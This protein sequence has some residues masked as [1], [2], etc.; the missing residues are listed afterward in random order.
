MVRCLGVI[1]ATL[2]VTACAWTPA[3]AHP[4]DG[5]FAVAR[6]LRPT[7]AAR[8]PDGTILVAGY[9]AGGSGS[10]RARE[11]VAIR[12]DG[13]REA[14]R[15]FRATGIE[16]AHDGSVLGIDDTAHVIRRWIRGATPTVVAGI[17]DGQEGFSG[18]GGPATEARLHLFDSSHGLQPLRAGG[19]RFTDTNN[20]RIREVDPAGTIRTVTCCLPQ[21]T[22][23]A[24]LPDG[25]S[26]ATNVFGTRLVLVGHDGRRSKLLG[27]LDHVVA[28][29]T[30]RSGAVVFHQQFYD[31]LT[32]LDPGGSRASPYL[33]NTPSRPFDFAARGFFWTGGLSSDGRGGLFA[34]DQG[35][36]VYVTTRRIAQ[37]LIALRD[38]RFGPRRLEAVVETTRPGTAVLEVLRRGRVVHRTSA[39]V[40]AGHN[41][42][43]SELRARS[44]WYRVRV[45]LGRSTDSVYVHGARALRIPLARRILGHY[46]YDKE[47]GAEVYLGRRCRSFGPRRVDCVFRS[48]DP[49]FDPPGQTGCEVLMS[50]QLRR[51]GVLL[52]RGYECWR[53]FPI[54][55]ERRPRWSFAIGVEALD[56]FYWR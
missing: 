43:A 51:S 54:R 2:G 39:R 33:A 1:A 34:M 11:V 35:N 48:H 4:G 47:N 40:R 28:M 24:G 56:P 18:D 55:F 41:T 9:E 31:E 13:R 16:V 38:L 26:V 25:R 20:G 17:E 8:L 53:N 46:G 15:G 42:L 30:L 3:L 19:F 6:G 50:L 52:R 12:P 37:A 5:T 7:D 27:S 14:I 44:R 10:S 32:R 49:E 36:L 23:L 45:R 21:P 22:I 29:T